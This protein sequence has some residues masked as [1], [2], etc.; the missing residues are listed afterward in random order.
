MRINLRDKLDS[1]MISA[2]A[3]LAAE[4]AEHR[5]HVMLDYTKTSP[6]LVWE[7][8]ALVDQSSAEF[9]TGKSYGAVK[10]WAERGYLVPVKTIGTAPLFDV[11]FVEHLLQTDSFA[12]SEDQLCEA[13][14]LARAFWAWVP[15]D[16]MKAAP[17]SPAERIASMPFMESLYNFVNERLAEVAILRRAAEAEAAK[18][19]PKKRTA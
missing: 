14:W 7:R 15:R 17:D 6:R 5:V 13:A 16:G 11:A 4:R 19:K 1:S 8:H 2:Q 10:K 9:H 18:G 3:L 12:A